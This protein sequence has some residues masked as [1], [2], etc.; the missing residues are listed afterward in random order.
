MYLSDNAKLY[1]L[2]MQVVT[3]FGKDVVFSGN[4]LP[5]YFPESS[6]R[7]FHP[8]MKNTGEIGFFIV[9]QFISY[10]RNTFITI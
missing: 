4:H 6:R 9:S 5:R 8:G 1:Y 7:N 3:V 2:E 10:F